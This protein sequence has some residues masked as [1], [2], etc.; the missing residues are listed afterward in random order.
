[1]CILKDER[2]TLRS[3]SGSRGGKEA[4]FVQ[5]AGGS[6]V[7]MNVRLYQDNKAMATN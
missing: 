7:N 4:V 5:I 2:H 3:E 1:M 6:K